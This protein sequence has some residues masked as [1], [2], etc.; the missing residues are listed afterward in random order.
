LLSGTRVVVSDVRFYST[1]ETDDGEPVSG[2]DAS[3]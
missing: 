2:A 1:W 3:A